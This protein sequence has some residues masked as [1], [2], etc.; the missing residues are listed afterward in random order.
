MN[1]GYSLLMALLLGT[2][3]FTTQSCKTGGGTIKD[4]DE[5]YSH[6]LYSNAINIYKRVYTKAK[7]PDKASL[8]FKI[9]EAYRLN[10]QY[11]Q[12]QNW[13]QKAVNA[14]YKNPEVYYKDAYV[15]K[16]AEKYDEAIEQYKL[17]EKEK[18]SDAARAEEQIN[19]INEFRNGKQD[20][21]Q[22]YIV[23]NFKMANSN[24]NDFAPS[25]MPKE[26]LTLTSD[27]DDATGK[28]TFGR[29]GLK[30]TDIFLLAKK[31]V[32]KV[33]K[34]QTPITVLPGTVNNDKN[35][36]CATFDAKGDV[37]YYTDCNGPRVDD[38]KKKAPNCVIRSARKKG[39]EWEPDAALPFC[40]DTTINY[41]QPGLSP[42]G[43]KM[44][45]AMNGPQTKGGHDLYLSTYVKRSRTWSDPIPLG[46]NINTEGDEG[47][48]YFFNDT[49]LYFASDG[50]PGLG[51][52]DLFVTTGTG[53]TWSKPKHLR[54]P[55]NS[56]GDDFAITFEDNK[57]SGYFASNRPQSRGDDIYSFTVQPQVFTLSGVMSYKENKQPV[58][59]ATIILIDENTKAKQ[60]VTTDKKGFYKFT[61]KAGTK[62]MVYGTK[63]GFF[64]SEKEYPTTV[65]LECSKDLVADLQ[66]TQNITISV[67][68]IYYDL[69]QARIRADAKPVLDSLYSVLQ[70]YPYMV[71]EVGSHTD[72]RASYHHNDSL[73]QARA[74]S[75]VAYLVNKGIEKERLVAKGYGER[76][77]VNNCACEPNDQGPG[78]DCT[79]EE[80]A[81]N[82]RSTFKILRTDFV[83]KTQ[84]GDDDENK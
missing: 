84:P 60:S 57:V 10:S 36:G 41:G 6:E 29:S 82:R 32:G 46:D 33:E 34:W 35:Q 54:S 65:G 74:D 75:V 24:K 62:Y 1:K 70:T 52:L 40:T 16:M 11:T 4:G 58:Q 68:N 83:P 28:K 27:R 30:Y 69:D 53:D 61:L 3:L 18:P 71:F 73:S 21:C 77:L 50:L 23:D 47:Y 78:K 25:V 63:K 67:S 37:M 43:T 8:A 26:G 72:C 38:P 15:L 66:I 79:E 64:N 80:H 56:G 13:Y 7:G 55:M 22:L 48:P 31:K 5:A 59:G 19:V 81:A 2:V 42:D 51:G 44:I 17:Y 14:G 39:K 12:A 20:N 49:T 76:M 9:A 45:F